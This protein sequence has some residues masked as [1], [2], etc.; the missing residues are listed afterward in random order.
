M[1]LFHGMQVVWEKVL[2][3]YAFT[4]K[5]VALADWFVSCICFI[6][7]MCLSVVPLH[8][9]LQTQMRDIMSAVVGLHLWLIR[10][11]IPRLFV[12]Q[13]LCNSLLTYFQSV[14]LRSSS[15]HNS[16]KTNE[17]QHSC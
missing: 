8:D 12:K 11:Q 14:W 7:L 13:A 1:F 4:E 2:E 6:T 10:C 16:S 9:L 3:V 17:W 5:E 15:T